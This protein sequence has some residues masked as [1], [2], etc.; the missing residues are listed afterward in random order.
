MTLS[1]C[2][3]GSF[4]D[5]SVSKAAH[6]V[7]GWGGGEG[8]DRPGWPALLKGKAASWGPICITGTWGT[9]HLAVLGKKNGRMGEI[10]VGRK[11]RT[12]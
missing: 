6:S 2:L 3:S 7:W 8:C 1:L 4:C 5:R 12:F 9:D 10:R 11:E